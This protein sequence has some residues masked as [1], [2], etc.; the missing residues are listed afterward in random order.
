MWLKERHATHKMGEPCLQQESDEECK[1][2]APGLVCAKTAWHPVPK[3]GYCYDEKHPETPQ[4]RKVCPELIVREN[5]VILIYVQVVSVGSVVSRS[6][7]RR[8]AFL[9]R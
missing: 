1:N 2:C 8:S 3:P 4:M 7:R 6:W 9:V 5:A